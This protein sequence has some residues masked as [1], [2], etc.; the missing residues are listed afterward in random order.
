MYCHGI[1]TS[2]MSGEDCMGEWRTFEEIA[3]RIRAGLQP[4]ERSY[5]LTT[6]GLPFLDRY[7]PEGGT[8]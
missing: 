6:K 5:I 7:Y 8:T 4:A 3:S 1:F 2:H